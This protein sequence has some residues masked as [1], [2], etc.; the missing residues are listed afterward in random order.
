MALE[1]LLDVPLFVDQCAIWNRR[2]REAVLSQGL[3]IYEGEVIAFL[4]LKVVE[5]SLTLHILSKLGE[6]HAILL[7]VHVHLHL[8]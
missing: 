7:A 5:F 2:R 8:R 3:P 4:P 6:P 1:E